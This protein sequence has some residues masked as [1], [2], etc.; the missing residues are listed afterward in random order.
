MVIASLFALANFSYMFFILRAQQF[1]AGALSVGAPLLL[2]ILFNIVYAG[3]SIPSGV[4]SDRLGRKNVLTGGYALFAL[5]ALSFAFVS[6]TAGL[7]VLFMLYV[8]VFA[9]VDGAQSAF[10][11]DLSH[12]QSRS[13]S[14]GLYYGSVGFASIISGAI[15][16]VLWQSRGAE[17]TFLFGAVFAALAALALLRM[18]KIEAIA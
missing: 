10:V 7:V 16:G 17:T 4:L 18:R 15:A 6:S 5:V 9:M 1:F 11:S 2:Y 8:L 13:T 14:L 3:L 12:A